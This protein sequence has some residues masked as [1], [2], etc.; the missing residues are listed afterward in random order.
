MYNKLRFRIKVQPLQV[1][2]LTLIL[3]LPLAAPAKKTNV[4]LDLSLEELLEVSVSKAEKKNSRYIA[5]N[6]QVEFKKEKTH[7]IRLRR[8]NPVSNKQPQ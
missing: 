5:S 7:K 4:F 1:M 2:C 8:E 3:L 6:N